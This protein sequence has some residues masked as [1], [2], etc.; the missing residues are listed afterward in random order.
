MT[1]TRRS[2]FAEVAL[3][4]NHSSCLRR[5]ILKVFGFIFCILLFFPVYVHVLSQVF[6]LTIFNLLSC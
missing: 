1:D 5:P 2:G 4:V 3:L 6:P